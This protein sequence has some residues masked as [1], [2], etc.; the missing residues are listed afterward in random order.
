MDSQINTV[1]VI[2]TYNEA[3]RIAELISRI[4]YLQPEF[5]ILVVDDDSPDGTAGVAEGLARSTGRV[6]VL[7]HGK[8]S[9]LGRAYLDGFRYALSQKPSYERIIEMDADFSHDPGYLRDLIEAAESY[10]VVLGSRY[11]AG[12]RVVDWN[13]YRRLLSR[14]ANLYTRFWLRLRVRDSTSGFRCF[15]RKVL[16]NI[17]LE[18]ILSNGY[19]FQIE[20]LFRCQGSGYRLKEIPISFIER[21]KGRTKLGLAQIWE[22]AWG[23][24]ALA[25][26]RKP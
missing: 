15:R 11:I 26:C 16:E 20:V 13:F 23:V 4:L 24:P 2:P 7:R 22:A 10:D 9:G 12:G 3:Q 19:L 5:D 8:K 17:G 18:K 14:L 25:F 6:R 1:V 21:K